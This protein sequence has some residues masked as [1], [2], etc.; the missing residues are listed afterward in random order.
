MN[1]KT[2]FDAARNGD[3]ETTRACLDAGADPA[4]M[5]EYG[6][7]PLH[8]AAMGTN[9][10]DLSQVLAV[11]RLLIESG[12]PLESVGGG[13]RTPLYLAAEFSPSTEPVQLLLDAGANPH[14]RDE[15]GNHIVTN[16]MTP[17]VQELLS[18][19]TGEPLPEP[20]PPEPEPK[21]M[22]A[23]EWREAKRRLDA[24]FDRLSK[25]GLVALQDAGYTQG[26]GFADCAEVFRDR[27]GEGAGLHGFCYY[28][29]QDLN[30]AKRNSQLSL[31]FWGAPEGQ[32]L[33]MEKVGR[34]IV[35]TFQENGF[36]VSWNGSGCIRPIV[37]L[38]EIS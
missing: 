14:T 11:I 36:V 22:T 9:T 13:G 24:V 28:T 15:H 6:F 27:G 38:Q 8:C 34:L 2:I 32:P 20:P 37:Y 4:A 10:A 29:R 5:N 25:A 19:V 17:E 18:R 16:A 31:A 1:P 30:R 26:D 7:T 21:K 23:K 35:E 3:L 12:A 33:D